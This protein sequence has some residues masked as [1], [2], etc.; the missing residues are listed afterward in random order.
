M[1]KNKISWF[2]PNIGKE[3]LKQIHSS[4]KSNWLTQ[5]PKVKEFEKKMASYCK[6]P[7]AVAVSNGTTAIDIALKAINIKQGDEVI[8]PAMSY[9][10]TAS[11]ISYQNATPVFVDID[12]D[13]F[14]IDTK[15]IQKAINKKTK[16]V[17]FIDY[18]GNPSDIDKIISIAKKNNIQVLQDGAQSLG[19]LY[20]GR[21]TGANA[22]ISTMSFHMAKIM[23]C[24]EG[25]MVFTHSKKLYEDIKMRR[26]HGENKPGDYK[27]NILGTNARMTDLN[28]GIGLAQFKKLN[29]F[30]KQRKKIAKYYDSLI[31]DINEISKIKT[32]PF[33]SNSYFF[34][35]ILLK[36]RDKIAKRLKSHY[37]IDT[38]VA[39]SLPIYN[40]AIYKK[41]L[42]KYKKFPCPVAE[43]ITKTI[44]NLPMY[45]AL[46]FS[47]IKY[48][49][50]S[51]KQEIKNN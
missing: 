28:A 14:N 43:K 29:Y 34:Y 2:K 9:F 25:G 16:A 3:E 23:S 37:G 46:K 40:Q 45:P 38:R 49:V 31:K 21:P 13:T 48:I 17:M 19:G 22:K 39:Y 44:L 50:N 18:G 7:Y 12:K 26:S 6:A 35:P 5:G 15:K 20:K 24:V 42:N 33:S 4:F 30:I 27:H 41:K 51:L 32:I 47:E 36:N 1:K 11:M 8:L 10:S